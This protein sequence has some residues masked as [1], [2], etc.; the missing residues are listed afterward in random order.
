MILTSTMSPMLWKLSL[1]NLDTLDEHDS[2]TCPGRT[3]INLIEQDN[4][5]YLQ[6][7]PPQRLRNELTL[8]F[9]RDSCKL[10]SPIAQLTKRKTPCM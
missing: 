7:Y 3:R 9:F 5:F 1:R 6:S 2:F 10:P 8:L 4:S